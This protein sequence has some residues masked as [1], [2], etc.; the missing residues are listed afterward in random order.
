MASGMNTQEILQPPLELTHY[1]SKREG[2][3]N[4]L[5]SVSR[6]LL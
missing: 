5:L 6:E 1:L 4:P 3:S 2:Y